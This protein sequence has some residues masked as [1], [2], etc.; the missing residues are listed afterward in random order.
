MAAAAEAAGFDACSV[1]DHPFPPAAW[2]A[3]GGHHALDPLVTLAVAAAATSPAAAAHQHVHPRLRQSI[4]RRQGRRHPGR[5]VPGARHPRGGGGLLEGG[6]RCPWLP[7]RAAPPDARRRDRRDEA[8][9][10]RRTGGRGRARLVGPRQRD[11]AGAGN[12]AAP[13]RLDR[14]QL[15]GRVAP[16]SRDGWVPFPAR[17]AMAKAVRTAEVGDVADLRRSIEAMRAEADRRDRRGAPLDVCVTPFSHPHDRAPFGRRC[18]RGKRRKW[19]AS[20]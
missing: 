20:G 11:A 5:A 15:P 3:G 13:A 12:A 10:V 6:V 9:V 17:R 19:P 8:G 1:T 7:L 16:R 2:V 18:W 14:R 4:H